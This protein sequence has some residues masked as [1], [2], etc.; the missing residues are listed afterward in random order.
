MFVTNYTMF[1][2]LMHFSEE[3]LQ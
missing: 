1:T 2:S 3:F